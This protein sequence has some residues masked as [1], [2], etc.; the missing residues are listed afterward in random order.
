[1]SLRG[2]QES[3]KVGVESL[4]SVRRERDDG[5][6]VTIGTDNDNTALFHIDTVLGVER[7]AGPG[8]R[9]ALVENVVGI[10]L[11]A[12]DAQVVGD[13]FNLPLR[14]GRGK[15]GEKGEKGVEDK[16]SLVVLNVFR[17]GL[18][19]DNRSGARGSMN[20]DKG[21]GSREK[22]VKLG[23]TRLRGL[24]FTSEDMN[25]ASPA[26]SSQRQTSR[27]MTRKTRPHLKA[28]FILTS[29]WRRT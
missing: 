8:F 14:V 15:D 4:E 20:V 19:V 26:N 2:A 29:C 11:V 1:M 3:S 25:S 7:G 6:H 23:E 27:Q 18:S 10:N 21:R 24:E 12:A 9:N 17:T 28:P 22:G 5:A 16:G 13:V